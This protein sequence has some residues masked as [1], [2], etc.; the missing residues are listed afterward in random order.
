[1]EPIN[2]YPVRASGFV[3]Y[4]KAKNKAREVMEIFNINK[5]PVDMH[6]II[7][8]LDIIVRSFSELSEA[9]VRDFRE[10]SC[11]AAVSWV[12]PKKQFLIIYD[13]EKM[14]ERIRFTLAHELGHIVLGHVPKS[15]ILKRSHKQNDPIE[16]EANTFAAELLRSEFLLKILG[17]SDR[18]SIEKICDISPTAA[19][20]A[21]EKVQ[22]LQP[23]IPYVPGSPFDFYANQFSEYVYMTKNRHEC[24]NCK[25]DF[26][27]QDANYC[28]ICGSKDFS[29]YHYDSKLNETIF[30][31]N[32]SNRC[33]NYHCYHQ[34]TFSSNIRFCPKCGSE[35][36]YYIRGLLLPWGYKGSRYVTFHDFKWDELIDYQYPNSPQYNWFSMIKIATNFL[37]IYS[38]EN[39]AILFLV[40]EKVFGWFPQN[41]P[42]TS[43]PYKDLYFLVTSNYSLDFSV[44]IGLAKQLRK[45]R[46]L[47]VALA[48]TG[49]IAPK[50][51]EDG[52]EILN[53]YIAEVDNI[54]RL[55]DIFFDPQSEDYIKSAIHLLTRKNL[56][57]I[58]THRDDLDITERFLFF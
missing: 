17:I 47:L 56:A 3:D 14:R 9:Q 29:R 11:D 57:E 8:T 15:G 33:S 49:K 48:H 31:E 34:I 2:L 51:S 36:D 53:R 41:N 5:L 4:P 23:V 1:M 50:T 46:F 24:N 16:V 28:P 58:S 13:D 35:T 26:S 39:K 18:T 42:E 54:N 40:L 7:K 32:T 21:E 20:I 45:Y 43:Y 10:E 27:I 55:V 6:K 38:A 22:T 37:K 52:W 30:N 12:A 44:I 19:L 25:A